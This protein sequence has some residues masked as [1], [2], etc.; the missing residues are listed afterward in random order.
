ML[1]Y[2]AVKEAILQLKNLRKQE[3]NLKQTTEKMQSKAFASVTKLVEASDG[4]KMI[5]LMQHRVTDECLPMFIANSTMRKT[6]KIIRTNRLNGKIFWSAN[7]DF[8]TSS[9]SISRVALGCGRITSS[10]CGCLLAPRRS[11]PPEHSTTVTETST[12]QQRMEM[13]LRF[14]LLLCFFSN[15][16]ADEVDPLYHNTSDS[17]IHLATKSNTQPPCHVTVDDFSAQRLADIV[18]GLDIKLLQI[19]LVFPDT[20][21]LLHTVI[22]IQPTYWYW[23]YTPIKGSFPYFKWPT[24]VSILS[25]G[26]LDAYTLKDYRLH[27]NA[28]P[29][30]C[31]LELGSKDA[32]RAISSALANMTT[33]H[34]TRMSQY[35][36]SY[37]CYLEEFPGAK[38]T[39]AYSL[40]AYTGYP[41]EFEGYRCCQFR[42]NRTARDRYVKC[43]DTPLN[44]WAPVMVIPFVLSI[45]LLLYSPF[46]FMTMSVAASEQ[47]YESE[48]A[49][50]NGY[51]DLDSNYIQTETV[52]CF[53][54]TYHELLNTTV[55]I[56]K[57]MLEGPPNSK[58]DGNTLVLSLPETGNQLRINETVLTITD[59]HRGVI[60]NGNGSS[61]R[62]Y[63]RYF[64]LR[65][66]I[67]KSLFLHIVRKHRPVHI[68]LFFTFLE[69]ICICSLVYISL[70]A[71]NQFYFKRDDSGIVKVL[72]ILVMGT[73]PQILRS[74]FLDKHREIEDANKRRRLEHTI[75][76]C[77]QNIKYTQSS[78]PI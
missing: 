62:L 70:T 43:Y 32:Q 46:M 5:D 68:Q 39:F 59:E 4:L 6:Q 66:A 55:S 69:L 26:L 15:A 67:E 49:Y 33:T 19:S 7:L 2:H 17:N 8:P 23:S 11:T 53:G 9:D 65:P 38:D 31:V 20:V 60:N 76:E 42:L 52:H 22:A 71:F 12:R 41:A 16:S 63:M 21:K 74:I 3:V 64:N 50:R 45:V 13:S 30:N 14:C 51:I 29:E 72:S 44:K 27:M 77:F 56:C 1:K 34:L 48:K 40:S 73:L 25:F 24:D 28:Y 75:V 78:Q 57:K 58:I 47:G 35:N 37:W 36:Y 10:V 54:K 61:K 18:V